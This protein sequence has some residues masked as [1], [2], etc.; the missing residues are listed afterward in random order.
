M[1]TITG[2]TNLDLNPRYHRRANQNASPRGRRRAFTLIELLVVI[3]IIAILAAMLLPALSKAKLKAQSITCVSN[4]K[5]LSLAWV[6][7]SGDFN[8]KLVPNWPGHPLAWID[9]AQGSVHQLPGATNV[10][11]LRKGL[12]YPYNPADGIY[13]CPTA[14]GG[15]V[16]IKGVTLVRH[17][18]LEGRMGGGTGKNGSPDTTWVLGAKY[19][20]YE[21]LV[22]I[23]DPSPSEAMTFLDESLPCLDDGYFAVNATTPTVWQNS[24]TARHGN[25]GVLAFADGHAE[26]WKWRAISVEQDLDSPVKKYGPDTTVDLKRI[27]QA[28]YR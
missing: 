8:D 4:Q 2:K 3:A 14:K 27:Q 21:K 5:Q 18:S 1:N 22:Q 25:A 26:R 13:Q 6:M 9:G 16:G 20:Q 10:L 28:V 17:V 15:P 7:Y 23:K 24:P 11:A 12:L 19:P